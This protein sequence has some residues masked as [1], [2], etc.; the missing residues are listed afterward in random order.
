MGNHRTYLQCASTILFNATGI[1]TN[2]ERWQCKFGLGKV[3]VVDCRFS[4]EDIVH[5]SQDKISRDALLLQLA[6]RRQQIMKA[7]TFLEDE[8]EPIPVGNAQAALCKVNFG[9]FWYS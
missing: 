1:P 8:R 2:A 5:F 7:N 4:I 9:R 3:L 6:Y